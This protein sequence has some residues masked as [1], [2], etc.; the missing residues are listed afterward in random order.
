[1]HLL[2]CWS[3]NP[4]E[5]LLAVS[6]QKDQMSRGY[7]KLRNPCFAELTAVSPRCA[8]PKLCAFQLSVHFSAAT[9]EP[10]LSEPAASR[11]LG[12]QFAG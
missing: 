7:V 4:W 12:R 5:Q 1:M 9:K 10:E 2:N 11:C 3:A 6:H 8:M